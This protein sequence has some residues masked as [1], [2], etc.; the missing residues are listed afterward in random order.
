MKKR[1]TSDSHRSIRGITEPVFREA[2]KKKGDMTIGQYITEA[3]KRLNKE[4]K[5][6]GLE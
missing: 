4:R 5:N 3:L 1:N 6:G 2:M